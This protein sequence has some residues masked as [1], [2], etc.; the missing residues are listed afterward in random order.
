MCTDWWHN[1]KTVRLL[2]WMQ[3]HSP[4]QNHGSDY[5]Y[6]VV[7][8]VSV[9]TPPE[10]NASRISP[11]SIIRTCPTHRTH[12]HC[13]NHACKPYLVFRETCT[14]MITELGLC[15]CLQFVPRWAM[16]H[17]SKM[18]LQ[19]QFSV[20]C[21]IFDNL[22]HAQ[23]CP[24]QETLWTLQQKASPRHIQFTISQL[25]PSLHFFFTS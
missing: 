5:A 9:S 21:L 19:L 15:I 16:M 4:G 24:Y 1:D 11:A 8:Y 12:A 13:L 22:I 10:V 20:I 18:P 3:A 14:D 7:I 6:N 2:N 17:L 25:V 23:H